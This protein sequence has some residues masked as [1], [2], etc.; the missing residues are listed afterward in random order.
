M[1]TVPI[2]KIPST[3]R[4]SSELIAL[5]SEGLLTC[6]ISAICQFVNIKTTPIPTRLPAS[7]LALVDDMA[8]RSGLDRSGMTEVLLRKGLA[9]IRMDLAIVA[10]D[11]GQVTLSRAWNRGQWLL[12]VKEKRRYWPP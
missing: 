10:Y 2:L 4:T 11:N 5:K 1:A 12:R 6:L 7:E 8:A 9:E 3:T